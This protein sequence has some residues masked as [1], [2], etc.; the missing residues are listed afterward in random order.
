[1]T[2]ANQKWKAGKENVARVGRGGQGEPLMRPF[3]V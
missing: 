2:S 3:N 1:M